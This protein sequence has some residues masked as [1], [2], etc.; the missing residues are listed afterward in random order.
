MPSAIKFSTS[1]NGSS[2]PTERLNILSD[3]AVNIGSSP[4]QA[5]G[6]HTANA[7]L[8]AK[9][10]PGDQTSAAILALVRG[11]TL[12]QLLLVIH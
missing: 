3:G 12:H 1:A 4:A 7:I 5:T 10:Y 8:T 9:G 2:T 6:T 11:N